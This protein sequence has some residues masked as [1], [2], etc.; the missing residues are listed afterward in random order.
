MDAK[1]TRREAI[2]GSLAA[3]PLALGAWPARRVSRMRFGF[4]TYTWGKEWDIPTI[5]A[6]CT[7]AKA[8]GVELRTS[9]QYAHGVELELGEAGRGEAKKRFADSP[10]TLVGLACGEK[11]DHPDPAKLKAAIENAK[12]YA[13]LSHDVGGRGVRVFPNDFQKGVPEDKTIEQIARSLNEVGKYAAGYNQM[14][15]LENHG[16][17]GRLTTLRKIMDQVTEK[18][19][20]IKLNCDAK[21]DE[22]GQFERNFNLVKGFLGDTL[23]MHDLRDEKFPYQ[24]QTNLLID[25]GWEGWWL[26]E[27]SSKVPD[28]VQ[29]LIE[30][31][32][33]FE[34]LVAKSLSR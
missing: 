15:R 20:R 32:Q 30:L 34:G 22:G 31:R 9:G 29:A 33:L 4:T 12:G 14:M 7:R 26:V 25:M 10:V 6:N 24:L 27:E 16:N 13:K 21:D 1:I 5:V 23:H 3:L 11:F 2:L 18:S 19:V 17:A 28:R 8:L